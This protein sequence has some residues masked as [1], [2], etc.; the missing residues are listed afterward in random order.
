MV[1]NEARLVAFYT[2]LHDETLTMMQLREF[3]SQ[4]L[5]RY[6]LPNHFIL[7]QRLPLTPSGKIDRKALAL[8]TEDNSVS[9][10]AMFKAPVSAT[11]KYYAKVWAECLS[12]DS[13]S[14][15]DNFFDIGGHSLMAT[16]VVARVSR[17]QGV[18][19]ELRSLLMNTLAQIALQYPLNIE[20]DTGMEN[21]VI[22]ADNGI[23]AACSRGSGINVDSGII[24]RINYKLKQ[25]L[26]RL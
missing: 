24:A 4:A 21:C 15:D 8:R 1:N 17:D 12:I 7:E 18:N 9:A 25:F 2:C 23:G 14:L 22:D 10:A 26:G 13:V 19:L 6:M 20:N 5:P 16:R 3:L 11:E